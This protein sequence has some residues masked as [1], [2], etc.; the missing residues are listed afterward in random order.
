MPE[1]R[2]TATMVHRFCVADIVVVTRSHPFDP[3]RPPLRRHEGL[4]E[5]VGLSPDQAV[6]EL[7]A[8]YRLSPYNNLAEGF[9]GL[10]YVRAGRTREAQQVLERLLDFQRSGRDFAVSIALIQHALGNDDEALQWLEKGAEQ[11]SDW[12]EEIYA[13]PHWD[14]LRSHPRVQAILRKMNLVK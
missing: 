12:L 8:A 7:E 6:A 10:A 2:T 11:R 5:G 9:R 14:S 1:P 13:S 4:G 3:L